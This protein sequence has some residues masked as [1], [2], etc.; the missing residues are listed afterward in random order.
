MKQTLFLL[1]LLASISAQSQLILEKE[2][3]NSIGITGSNAIQ[4]ADG[5]YFFTANAFPASYDSS[6]ALLIKTDSLLQPVWTQRYKLLHNDQIICITPSLDGN[7]FLGGTG[8]E[9]FNQLSGGSLYK[10]DSMGTVLWHWIYSDSY[11]DAVIKVFEQADSTLM[12]FIREGV[13]NH[14]TKVVYADKHGSMIS[15]RFFN[16]GLVNMEA[17]DV[18][19]DNSG[20]FIMSGTV[21]FGGGFPSLFLIGLNQ[22]AFNWFKEYNFGRTITNTAIERLDDGSFAV[23]GSISDSLYPNTYNSYLMK[24]D[25]NG[26]IVWTKEIQQPQ[27]F[28][29]FANS[30]GA[31][32][33]GDICISGHSTTA[34]GFKAF[35]GR[36]DGSG[37]I[38]W[39]ATYGSYPYQDFTSAIPVSDGRFLFI[40][41]TNTSRKIY[42]TLADASGASPCSYLPFTLTDTD[43]FPVVSTQAITTSQPTI[44]PVAP[45]IVTM[46]EVI[47]DS[48]FCIGQAGISEMNDGGFGFVY[49][50]PTA[51]QAT[52]VL[53]ATHGERVYLKLMNV[54]GEVI[55]HEE[56]EL[57]RGENRLKIELGEVNEG[58]YILI[59]EGKIV[60][61]S[62]KIV[63]SQMF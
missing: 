19:S 14:P 52:I 43:I 34:A 50:N 1:A 44:N 45:A 53:T 28:N 4:L 59:I 60:Y 41:F 57:A 25:V 48:V 54:L 3:S 33:N 7:F 40:G 22:S 2:F 30:I 35:G 12:I 55:K 23:T 18:A 13:S 5:S 51:G 11:D 29:E 17:E 16:S 6:I 32:P 42:V 21:A 49:P 37:N 47:S 24:I 56:V 61:P 58:L 62:L 36:L 8:R 31:L 27:A 63:V 15:Q 10:V 9:D 26:N 20:N 46:L 38:L 39:A